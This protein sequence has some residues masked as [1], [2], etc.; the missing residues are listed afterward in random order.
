MLPRI[1]TIA[2]I[3]HFEL[4]HLGLPTLTE[5]QSTIAGGSECYRIND[6]SVS[7]LDVISQWPRLNSL[8]MWSWK[9]SLLQY[10]NWSCDMHLEIK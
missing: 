1:L 6:A 10:E 7:S 5:I 2:S 9:L 8:D 4:Q 3:M